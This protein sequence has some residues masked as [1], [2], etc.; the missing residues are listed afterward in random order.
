MSVDASTLCA[1]IAVLEAALQS[2]E[3][4]RSELALG[5]LK[6][7]KDAETRAALVEQVNTVTALLTKSDRTISRLRSTVSDLSHRLADSESNFECLRAAAADTSRILRLAFRQVGNAL[8]DSESEGSEEES[9]G[10]G[11]VDED[12]GSSD[13]EAPGAPAPTCA[14][15]AKRPRHSKE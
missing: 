11:S 6:V 3:T 13:S 1:R 2:S 15:S 9:D 5:L 7:D 12:G 4:A 14:P 8:T 10:S